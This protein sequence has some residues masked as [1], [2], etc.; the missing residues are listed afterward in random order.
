M[1]SLSIILIISY[2]MLEKN[3]KAEKTYVKMVLTK[4]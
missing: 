1:K 2:W 4:I 3:E